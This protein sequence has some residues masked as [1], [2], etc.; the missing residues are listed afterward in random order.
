M[1]RYGLKAS[2]ILK[3]GRMARSKLFL[4]HGAAQDMHSQ[5]WVL[6]LGYLSIQKLLKRVLAESRRD[7]V[8]DRAAQLSFYFVLAFFPLMIFACSLAGKI[9]SSES[10][11][12]HAILSYMRPLLPPVGFQMLTTIFDQVLKTNHLHI[13][14]F[15]FALWSASYGL[16][17]VIDGLNEV[18]DVKE[19]RSWWKRRALALAMTAV[20]SVS[21]V[22]GIALI[23]WGSKL[24]HLAGTAGVKWLFWIGWPYARWTTAVV[25]LFLAVTIIYRVAPNL[26]KQ[27]LLSV[28]PGTVVAIGLWILASLAFR[29]YLSK[30]YGS[31]KSVYGSLGAPVATLLWLYLSGVALLLGAEVNSAIRWA[32]K[33]AGDRSASEALE[34]NRE[35]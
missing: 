22:F 8:L 32:A 7:G 1:E 4:S 15:C 28:L 17:A 27:T 13:I 23:A 26:R 10:E 5:K 33:E 2:G 34:E 29:L 3:T 14:S 6:K 11:F 20:L 24:G 25:F 12:S 31:Y 21:A 30:F 9:I 19:F 18:F 16:E 35:G